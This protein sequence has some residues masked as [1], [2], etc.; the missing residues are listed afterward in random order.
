MAKAKAKTSADTA[1]NLG[2]E[3]KLWFT[4]DKLRN[5]MNAAKNSQFV[6]GP[7][8]LKSSSDAFEKRHQKLIVKGCERTDSAASDEH[9]DCVPKPRDAVARLTEAVAAARR[10][11]HRRV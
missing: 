10:L 2:F 6:L 7:I 11:G 3:A 9:L 5:N 1:A 8:F 4:A